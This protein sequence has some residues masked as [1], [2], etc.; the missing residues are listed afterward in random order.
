MLQKNKKNY[1]IYIYKYLFLILI[2]MYVQKETKKILAQRCVIV[3]VE[4]VY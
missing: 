1:K 4:A 3:N 2:F